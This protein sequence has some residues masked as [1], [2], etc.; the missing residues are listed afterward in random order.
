MSE[1]N[2]NQIVGHKDIVF[3]VL[4]SLRYDVAIDEMNLGRTPNLAKLLPQSWEKRHSP[5]NFT[6]AAHS[7][8]FAGFLP[9]PADPEASPERLF[10]SQFHGSETTG[11]NT[12]TFSQA[13]LVSA[14]REQDYHTICIGGVGFFNK[15]SSLSRVF[16]DLFD[17]SHWSNEMG[18]TG[19]NSTETQF[20][21]AR[22]ILGERPPDQHTFLFLNVSSIHQPNCHYLDEKIDSLQSHAAALRYLDK[23]IPHLQQTLSQ[24]GAFL[25]LCSDHGTLYGEEGFIGHRVG[26]EAV[27]T[28]PYAHLLIDPA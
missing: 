11:T 20:S 21:L 28:V 15:Q 17:E 24:R 7:A 4:D 16:P 5:G 25:I 6:Y 1:I 8:F 19:K 22:K 23:L 27:Y 2:M 10:A 18:V 9:T 13:D 14:L 12:F 3:L 26:H